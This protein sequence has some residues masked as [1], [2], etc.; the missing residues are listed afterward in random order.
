MPVAQ[1][2]V[3]LVA[4]LGRAGPVHAP[5]SSTPGSESAM[6]AGSARPTSADR[7]L[8]VA[9]GVCVVLPA[10][11][12]LTGV[13]YMASADTFGPD[14]TPPP[15]AMPMAALGGLFFAVPFYLSLVRTTERAGTTLDG[16]EK[17]KR[18]GLAYVLGGALALVASV[19]FLLF[20][21]RA[22]LLGR[23]HLVCEITDSRTLTCTSDRPIPPES[24]RV[25]MSVFE[26]EPTLTEV[27][28]IEVGRTV[29]GAFVVVDGPHLRP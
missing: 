23:V 7:W 4:A 1:A 10:I 26:R 24:G 8:L 18:F 29:F 19:G 11:C 14:G 5:T 22:P 16:A 6:T 13:V 28:D 20:L 2:P 25:P 12:C 9:M 17:L 3:A 27:Y 15:L 21:G